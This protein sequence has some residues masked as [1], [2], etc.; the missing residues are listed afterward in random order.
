[1][2]IKCRGYCCICQCPLEPYIKTNNYE[3]RELVRKY[4]KINPLFLINND[5]YLK[6]FGLK[7]KRVCYSCLKTLKKP[8][9]E[10]L[11]SR[12][13]GKIQHI[14]RSLALSIKDLSFWYQGLCKYVNN[15]FHNRPIVVYND[16]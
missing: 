3:K 15:N 6:F 5:Q 8:S 11:R 2:Y 12:E 7:V 14:N 10:I 4:K 9:Q 1:M 16:I 13:I